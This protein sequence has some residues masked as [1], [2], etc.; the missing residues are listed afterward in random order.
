[1][2]RGIS[3]IVRTAV[4]VGA[5]GF[6]AGV[7]LVPNE[8]AD[9]FRAIVQGGLGAIDRVVHSDKAN[10]DI[11]PSESSQTNSPAETSR[12]EAQP[13]LPAGSQGW[14]GVQIQPVT[15][16]IADSLG[17][18][19]NKGALVA[20]A[21]QNSPASAA[22]IKS[23]DVIL[24]I[25][26]ERIDGPRD[27]TRQV[28]ALGPGKKVDLIY[29]RDGSEKTTS[30]NLGSLPDDKEARARPDASQDNNAFS[31]L[32]LTLALASSVQGAGSDGV[33]VSDID[34]DGIAA[35]KG[36]QIGDVILEAGGRVVNQP[37]DISAALAEAKKDNRKA[38]LLRVKGSEGTH[39]VAIVVKPA[40]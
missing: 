19:S 2:A 37:A 6:G 40:S 25:D 23:G 8:K 13:D 29:W 11:H 20:E 22:G 15:T 9:Q 10:P 7:Y 5:I 16:E 38:V 34:P 32:G 35:Q 14:I 18:K 36:L 4:V 27:L 3:S 28:A 17:L 30:V 39:F 24:G 26:G 21:Q 33:V 31:G 1:M 12:T